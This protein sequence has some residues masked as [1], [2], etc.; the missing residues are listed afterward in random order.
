MNIW[1]QIPPERSCS[2]LMF[3]WFCTL[4]CLQYHW[5]FCA[6]SLNGLCKSIEL[7]A[8]IFHAHSS[9]PFPIWDK[10]L[11]MIPLFWQEAVF[12]GSYFSPFHLS[13]S[14][15]CE[16]PMVAQCEA[17]IVSVPFCPTQARCFACERIRKEDVSTELILK[18]PFVSI[19][20]AF[21]AM[22]RWGTDMW[23]ID[24]EEEWESGN[25]F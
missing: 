21:A 9:F 2:I 5:V 18:L 22:R 8:S 1:M 13:I 6:W 16:S 12:N 17:V 23:R 19:T 7:G 10:I 4:K 24:E 3:Y 15:K 14:L 25:F 11:Q 20:L